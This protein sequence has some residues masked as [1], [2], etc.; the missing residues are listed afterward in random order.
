M[1]DHKTNQLLDE[2]MKCIAACE[3]C[4]DACLSEDNPATMADCIRI[5]RHCADV[6]STVARFV[7]RDSQ[8]IGAAL[9]NCIIICNDC[10]DTCSQHHHDHCQKCAEVCRNCVELCQEYTGAVHAGVGLN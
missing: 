3:T 2:L 8:Y 5:N 9:Q 4:A 6:C 7:A 10:A 1:K